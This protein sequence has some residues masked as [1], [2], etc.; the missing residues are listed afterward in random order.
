MYLNHLKTGMTVRF[1]NNK[2]GVVLRGLPSIQGN[3]VDDDP[4]ILPNHSNIILG[5]GI[6]RNQESW[7]KLEWWNNSLKFAE[8]NLKDG[9]I[10]SG[11][12]IMAVYKPPRLD[13]KMF[14]GLDKNWHLLIWKRVETESKKVEQPKR[15]PKRKITIK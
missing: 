13:V 8:P 5:T 2:R 10:D 11:W 12:D 3:N 6:N 14:E 7:G 9:K 1:R 15:Q 4:D